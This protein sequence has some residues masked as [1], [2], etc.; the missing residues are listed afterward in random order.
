MK[1]ARSRKLANEGLL[2]SFTPMGDDFSGLDSTQTDSKRTLP[3]E[4]RVAG[5]DET[6]A[7]DRGLGGGSCASLPV[8][9]PRL[10][11]PQ[12]PGKTFKRAGRCWSS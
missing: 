1:S 7:A 10:R 9:A 6:G 8:W 2:L 11:G 3:R 4:H 5:Q 12:T